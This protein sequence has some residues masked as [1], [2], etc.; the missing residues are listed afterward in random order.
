MKTGIVVPAPKKLDPAQSLAALYGAML[1]KF[2]TRAGWTQRELGDRVPIAHSRIAQFELGNETPVPDVAEALDRLV[3]ADGELMDLWRHVVR[4]PIPDWAQRYVNL[5]PQAAKI[6]KYQAQTVPGLLQTEAYA[7]ALLAGSRP[8]VG[9]ALEKL[10]TARL[11]RQ[12]ILGAE[13]APVLWAILDEAVLRRPLGTPDAMKQQLEYLIAVSDLHSVVLQVLELDQGDHPLLGGSTTVLSFSAQP[14]VAYV[15]S[16]FSGELVEHPGTVA[17]FALALDHLQ[18]L[19]LSPQASVDLIRS[20]IEEKYCDPRLPAR[21][22]RR[23]L[24]Q[25]QLQQRAGRRLRRGR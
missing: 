16:A 25:V 13:T 15:E 24:A 20:I 9:A 10:L 4:T 12:A 17:E 2:R 1:R 7:R 3:K 23:R 21:V 22:R 5:E 8:S 6:R 18:A 19:A 14:D 11:A